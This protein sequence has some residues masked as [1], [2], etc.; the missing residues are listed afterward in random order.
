M[1]VDKPSASGSENSHLPSSPSTSPRRADPFLKSFFPGSSCT[2]SGPP[3]LS[4]HSATTSTSDSPN[5]SVDDAHGV[6]YEDS[7]EDEE[8]EEVGVDTGSMSLD[9]SLPSSLNSPQTTGDEEGFTIT[10]KRPDSN[11]TAKES[12]KS[13]KKNRGIRKEDRIRRMLAHKVHLLCLLACGLYR[14]RWCN[15]LELRAI[16]LSI[17]PDDI[18]AAIKGKKADKGKGKQKSATHKKY[19][20]HYLQMLARWWKEQVKVKDTPSGQALQGPISLL[21]QFGSYLEKSHDD[22]SRY[23]SAESSALL[24]T[25]ACRALNLQTRLICSLHPIPLSLSSD[26]KSPSRSNGT[27]PRRRTVRDS[28]E[29]TIDE[30]PLSRATEES[31]PLGGRRRTTTVHVPYPLRYWCEVYSEDDKQWVAVDPVRGLVND[32]V[33]MEP[34]A[35][36][37]NQLQISYV[38]AYESG[39]VL[40]RVNMTHGAQRWVA[41]FGVK[42][43]TRRYT[44]QWGA[45]TVRLRLPPGAEGEDWWQQTLWFYSKSNK[46]EVDEKED[47]QLRKSEVKEKM[48]TSLAGFKDH[49]LYVF[50]VLCRKR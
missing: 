10:I 49:P 4:K 35:S 40:S 14:N 50:Q 42:D 46:G 34:P 28:D 37:G 32:T 3:E 23:V 36:V 44:S 16:T 12:V 20:I 8:W 30:E 48:P 33:V 9:I 2:T 41:D 11:E 21:D 38:V 17:L 1:N 47:E 13:V 25:A 18:Y 45:R 22:P 43:V 24:F 5:I 7:E 27:R 19:L 39:T 31:T 29:D 6:P 26:K 15:D